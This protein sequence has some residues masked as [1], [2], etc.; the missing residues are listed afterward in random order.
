MIIIALYHVRLKVITVLVCLEPL[1]ELGL[2]SGLCRALPYY[3][4]HAIPSMHFPLL[5]AQSVQM[6]CAYM[7]PHSPL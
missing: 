2:K 5:T 4:W 7:A 3:E 6:W 1:F